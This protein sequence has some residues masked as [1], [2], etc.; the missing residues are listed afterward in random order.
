MSRSRP[1]PYNLRSSLS[2]I[3]PA[4]DVPVSETSSRELKSLSYSLLFA[5]ITSII[6]LSALLYLLVYLSFFYV[7]KV[8]DYKANPDLKVLNFDDDFFDGFSLGVIS[9]FESISKTSVNCLYLYSKVRFV[10]D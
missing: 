7:V 8:G 1:R 4:L 10:L 5:E 3:S 6:C 2:A 9:Y